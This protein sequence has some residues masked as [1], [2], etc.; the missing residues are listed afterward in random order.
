LPAGGRPTYLR[1]RINYVASRGS[2]RRS[3]EDDWRPRV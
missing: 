3:V 1:G 2:C